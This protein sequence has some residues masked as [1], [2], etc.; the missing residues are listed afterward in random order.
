M[1]GLI[2]GR[3]RRD[4]RRFAVGA[5]IAVGVL[6]SIA[7][8]SYGLDVRQTDETRIPMADL[9]RPFSQSI[10]ICTAGSFLHSPDDGPASFELNARLDRPTEVVSVPIRLAL[11]GTAHEA[12]GTLDRSTV[13]L[14]LQLTVP[15]DEVAR[16]GDET[17]LDG[18]CSPWVEIRI[19]PATG[20][21]HQGALTWEL[22]AGADVW[23]S[24]AP[25]PWQK[26]V[27]LTI[28]S[29]GPR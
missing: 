20:D 15:T 23:V 9:D 14:G 8:S 11:P 6:A 4:L 19:G 24:G 29:R 26:D 22:I 1:P 7:T 3:L 5:V 21:L 27:D 18:E 2:P 28:E 13:A 16:W 17:S 10:R 25:L 12:V